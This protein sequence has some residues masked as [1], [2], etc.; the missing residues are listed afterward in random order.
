MGMT[1]T[2]M[3]RSTTARN[4]YSCTY[5]LLRFKPIQWYLNPRIDR[6]KTRHQWVLI[7]PV[8]G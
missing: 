8:S 1:Q 6:T 7:Y 5:M 3:S 2:P 4:V